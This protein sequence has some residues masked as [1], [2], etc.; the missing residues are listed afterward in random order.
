[1][2]TERDGVQ[3]SLYNPSIEEIVP[4]DDIYRQIEAAVDFTFIYDRLRPY[5]CPDNGRN[6]ADP[7]VVVKSLLIAF[8][9]GIPS[10]RKLERQLRLNAAYR[11][12]LGLRFDERVPDHSTISQLRRRKFND[13]E[14]IKELFMHILRLCAESGLVSGK[15]LVTD[16]THVKA[17]ASKASQMKI[18]IERTATEFFER[19]DAYEAAERERLGLPEIK[20]KPPQPKREEQIRSATDPES[21]WL[22]RPGKPDGFH[23]LS[24]QTLDT[25]HGI[26]V[27]VGVTPGHTHDGVPYI[28][29]I[30]RAVNTLHDMGIPAEAVCAD[31][32]YDSTMIHKDLDDRE[33][34]VHMVKTDSGESGKTEYRRDDFTYS[35]ET[36]SFVCPAG[37]TLTLRG[38]QR[39]VNGVYREYRSSPK[40]CRSCPHRIKCLAPSQTSRRL[41]VNI[42]QDIVDR[43]HQNDGSPQHSDALRKRQIWCEGTFAAQKARHN[44]GQMFRRGLR[45]AADHCFLSAC[46]I[47]LKRLVKYHAAA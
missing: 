37:Q 34:A 29:E 22:T 43:H 24:H 33:L 40:D 35:R 30:D 27:D 19:L 20:R 10:E 21:G 5:Y 7:V 14:I 16:S 25:E 45:A 17:N 42:F 2:M 28:E 46:A 15:L 44:L 26:I 11:W 47:N 32:A 13:A 3:Q 38:T 23:Y 41:C 9:E 18:E 36:D 12:F 31:A 6:S 8:L 4:E 39:L 1:M